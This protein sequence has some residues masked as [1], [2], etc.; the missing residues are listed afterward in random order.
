MAGSVDIGFGYIPKEAQL[1]LDKLKHSKN[2][3]DKEKA[4]DFIIRY[5]YED[6]AAVTKD[7]LADKAAADKQ[8]A[9]EDE[10]ALKAQNKQ[11]KKERLKAKKAWEEAAAKL[12]MTLRQYQRFVSQADEEDINRFLNRPGNGT[13]KYQGSYT[14]K[15]EA[16]EDFTR[17]NVSVPLKSLSN[18]LSKGPVADKDKAESSYSSESRP[19]VFDTLQQM[20]KDLEVSRQTGYDPNTVE[21]KEGME[22]PDVETFERGGDLAN[23]FDE[24]YRLLYYPVLKKE[25]AELEERKANG[26]SV[27]KEIEAKQ[28]RLARMEEEQAKYN[29]DLP[30]NDLITEYEDVK[31]E[32]ADTRANRKKAVEG[33]EGKFAKDKDTGKLVR[34][35]DGLKQINRKSLDAAKNVE[36]IDN[37]D[38]IYYGYLGEESPIL[39]TLVVPKKRKPG[40]NNVVDEYKDTFAADASEFKLKELTDILNEFEKADPKAYE[41]LIKEYG[42]DFDKLGDYI[43]KTIED[44]FKYYREPKQEPEDIRSSE[45]KLYDFLMGEKDTATYRDMQSRISGIDAN[46]P[47]GFDDALDYYKNYMKEADPKRYN[48]LFGEKEAPEELSSL[49]QILKGHGDFDKRYTAHRN[50]LADVLGRTMDGDESMGYSIKY[51]KLFDKAM[52][53]LASGNISTLDD[54]DAFE[55]ANFYKHNLKKLLNNANF[56]ADNPRGWYAANMAKYKLDKFKNE[57]AIAEL[58]QKTKDLMARKKEI[59]PLQKQQKEVLGLPKQLQSGNDADRHVT[60]AVTLPNG[61]QYISY[62]KN[63]VAANFMAIPDGKGGF[64]VYDNIIKQPQ[65]IVDAAEKEYKEQLRQAKLDY[66]DDDK[67]RKKAEYAAKAAYIS[68]IYS[69][70]VVADPIMF[71]ND[72]PRNIKRM[73]P[74]ARDN[75]FSTKLGIVDEALASQKAENRLKYRNRS[76]Q[77]T[78]ALNDFSNSGLDGISLDDYAHELALIPEDK[79][80]DRGQV[81]QIRRVFRSLA[82][83]GMYYSPKT[84]QV[85]VSP[86]SA[87]AAGVTKLNSPDQLN[88]VADKYT[89]ILLK[90]RLLRLKSAAADANNT[91]TYYDENGNLV[92][93]SKGQ[94]YSGQSGK[95][96]WFGEGYYNNDTGRFTRTKGGT[97][98]RGQQSMKSM[99]IGN[100]LDDYKNYGQDWD[101]IKSAQGEEH[102]AEAEKFWN[103]NVEGPVLNSLRKIDRSTPTAQAHYDKLKEELINAKLAELWEGVK[104]E[105]EKDKAAANAYTQPSNPK[106]ADAGMSNE[107]YGKLEKNAKKRVKSAEKKQETILP[108]PTGIANPADY[109]TSIARESASRN[110]R[111]DTYNKVKAANKRD[112]AKKI[113]GGE[114]W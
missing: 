34:L 19:E 52:Q 10:Q 54:D 22:L 95:S 32:L 102:G 37:D 93:E 77:I 98:D 39:N 23:L 31:K 50:S 6:Q 60:S 110:K 38:N 45:D 58:R 27:D 47:A 9:D 53:A 82:S 28:A 85:F 97:A 87:K 90:E 8:K 18:I 2:E 92:Q 62:A 109:M 106:R 114:G 36:D 12:G 14:G 7:L 103:D 61:S 86:E 13:G 41:E 80:V 81:E 108:N 100:Y 99:S 59:E 49:E 57:A 107:K 71:I 88:N 66:A 21:V 67:E 29:P 1:Y 24:R 64:K 112:D 70:D 78:D 113:T 83:K 40:V 91:S 72:A 65:D 51:P 94:N 35:A 33:Y 111:A 30:L 76:A 16:K 96:A 101:A 74:T 89:D 68:K 48:K 79:S 20:A 63:G 43:F 69:P 84:K 3:E 46:N 75:W 4:K 73:S 17:S 42:G 11:N 55:L 5:Q 105:K 15:D 44:K 56:A 26:E 104:K 25:L